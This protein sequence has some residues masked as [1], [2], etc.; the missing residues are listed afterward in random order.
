[1]SNISDISNDKYMENKLRII[2]EPLLCSLLAEKPK[3]PVYSNLFN[4]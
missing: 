2:I 4:I 1:M 3:D